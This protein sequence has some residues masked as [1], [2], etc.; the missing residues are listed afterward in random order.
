MGCFVL[1]KSNA[2][3]LTGTLCSITIYLL[4]LDCSYVIE[5]CTLGETHAREKKRRILLL[6]CMLMK[7]SG[8]GITLTARM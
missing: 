4:I 5:L 1:G 8:I 7:G 2:R 3:A 6:M